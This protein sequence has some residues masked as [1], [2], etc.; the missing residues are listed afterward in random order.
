MTSRSIF[1]GAI[2]GALAVGLGAIGAHALRERLS[3]GELEIWHTA[4]LYHALHALALVGY[5]LFAERRG[6]EGAAGTCFVLG[7][8]AFSGSLYGHALGGP[9]FLVYVTP[10]GGVLL[11]VAWLLFAFEAFREPRDRAG[12][13]P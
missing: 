8:L 7:V 13:G 3:A 2:L 5:G 12:A 6:R 4:A 9:R 11:I 10:V 1:A